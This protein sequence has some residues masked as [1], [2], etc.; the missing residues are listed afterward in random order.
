MAVFTLISEADAQV[1]LK[2]YDLGAFKSLTGIAAGIEN[3]NYFLE[4]SKG[5]FVLTIFEVLK[6]HEL[7]FYIELM[8]HLASKGMPVP[9]PQTQLSGKRLSSLHNKPTAIV[10]KLSGSW[11]P[12]PTPEHCKLAAQTLAQC[13]L[14]GVH[15]PIKQVNL[16]GSAWRQTTAPE[17]LPFLN[18]SQQTL[19]L[20][21]LKEDRLICQSSQWQAL[22][23]GPAHCDLFRDNVL[24]ESSGS[25]LKMG[26]FIDFY[27]AGVETFIFDIAVAINDWCID[28]NTGALNQDLA[29][30][31]LSAYSGVRSFTPEEKNLLPATLRIAALR[32]WVSRLYDFHMPRAAETLKPHDPA[33]FERILACRFDFEPTLL[34]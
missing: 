21:A 29:N 30:A 25:N 9:Q 26:G 24:F 15:A 32:F 5:S 17:I 10:S 12:T 27:F 3:T 2:N 8:H 6:A 11:V 20:D 14:A 1:F 31:W 18:A 4:T 13:H 28:C 7:P 23:S 33:H 34:N 22:P 19:M 16:R